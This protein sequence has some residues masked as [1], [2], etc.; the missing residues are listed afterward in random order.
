[1]IV[2]DATVRKLGE[3]RAAAEGLGASIEES[4]GLFVLTELELSKEVLKEASPESDENHPNNEFRDYSDTQPHFKDSWHVIM[5][6]DRSGVIENDS[7]QAHFVIA[8]GAKPHTI[9]PVE[10]DVMH[11]FFKDETE[12][13][14]GVPVNHPGM[15]RDEK[16]FAAVVE[17]AVRI[18]AAFAD[19]GGRIAVS[20]TRKFNPDR[21]P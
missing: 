12:G 6:S 20:H 14:F 21:L 13:F 3:V 5:V 9:A 2:F 19:I 16:L 15:Q 17:E 8:T 18:R 1:M 7:P 4:L 10:Q 11:F